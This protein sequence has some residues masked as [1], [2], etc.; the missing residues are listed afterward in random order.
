MIV[1]TFLAAIASFAV[2]AVVFVP[3]ERVFPARAQKIARPEWLVDVAFFAGQ[4]LAWSAAAVGFLSIVFPFVPRADVPLPLVVKVILA[5]AAGDFVVYWF[6]RACHAWEPLWRFHAVHHSA[7]HLDWIAAHREHPVDGI[8]TQLCM[9]LPA[10]AIGVPVEA[11]AGVAMFRG[12]WAIFV[13]SNVALPLGP[14]RYVLGAPELH[15]WHHAKVDRTEHNFANLAPW[16][17]VL[18]GTYHRPIGKETYA[19][20]IAEP[21]PRGYV[22]QLLHPFRLVLGSLASW[23]SPGSATSPS[24]RSFR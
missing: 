9:N 22:A 8:L 18:F 7:E 14:L 13:H 10:I 11:L 15:H 4:Y 20:G 24:S 6:H 3:L 16:L 23:M 5:I 12:L 17:D 19:L 1:S 21:W 2:L